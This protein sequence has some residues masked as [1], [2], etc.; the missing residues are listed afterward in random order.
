MNET[1]RRTPRPVTT[2]LL[3]DFVVW[4]RTADMFLSSPEG[5]TFAEELREVLKLA[6]ERLGQKKVSAMDNVTPTNS[7]AVRRDCHGHAEAIEFNGYTVLILASGAE[8]N[9]AWIERIVERLNG[10][11]TSLG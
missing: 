10:V 8:R 1:G 7:Y 9:E 4:T 6:A 3:V 5:A 11:E 2:D